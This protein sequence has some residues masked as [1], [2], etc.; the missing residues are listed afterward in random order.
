MS[1]ITDELVQAVHTTTPCHRN[2]SAKRAENIPSLYRCCRMVVQAALCVFVCTARPGR[3]GRPVRIP[4]TVTRGMEH[5][6]DSVID[7]AWYNE[8]A[9]WAA[10]FTGLHLDWASSVTVLSGTVAL[11]ERVDVLFLYKT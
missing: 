9:V 1:L 8:A 3:S 11:S 4:G 7:L 6:K 2:A 10:T 5:E